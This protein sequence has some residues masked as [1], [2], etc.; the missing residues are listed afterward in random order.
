MEANIFLSLFALRFSLLN[1][2]SSWSSF[3]GLGG[4]LGERNDGTN[5]KSIIEKSIIPIILLPT[6]PARGSTLL[7]GLPTGST[8]DENI[9]Y[10]PAGRFFISVALD[11][12]RTAVAEKGE[13]ESLETLQN[14]NLENFQDLKTFE[15]VWRP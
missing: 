5:Q 15:M 3:P 9:L 2:A 4:P 1:F 12:E 7:A 13:V 10:F 11:V 6:S 14:I 8:G